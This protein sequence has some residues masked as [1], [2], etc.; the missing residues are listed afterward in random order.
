M[1]ELTIGIYMRSVVQLEYEL[2]TNHDKKGCED[3]ICSLII[4]EITV[5]LIIPMVMVVMTRNF[6]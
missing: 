1:H 4:H 2:D 6:L 5:L 3:I